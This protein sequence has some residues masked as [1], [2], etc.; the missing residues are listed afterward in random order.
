ML[1]D[2]VVAHLR[3]EPLQDYRH[4]YVGSVASLGL[5][6]GVAQVY[7]VKFRGFVGLVHAPH[8]PR[9]PGADVQPQGP[10]H[11]RL[12]ARPLFR[13]DVVSLG[14]LVQPHRE[15]PTTRPRPMP[16]RGPDRLAAAVTA[17]S[18]GVRRLPLLAVTVLGH[19][20]PGIIADVTG[21][22]AAARRQSRGLHD[23]DAARAFAMMLIVARAPPFRP[24]SSGRSR[25]RRTADHS[26]S[27]Y[28]RSPGVGGVAGSTGR[29]PAHM[30]TGRSPR[31][32]LRR[33]TRVVADVNGNIT[34][35]TTRLAGELYPRWLP[36]SSFRPR[37]T[38]PA[39]SAALTERAHELGVEAT[40]RPAEAD[41]L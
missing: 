25:P 17:A 10:G 4:K 23:D 3:G 38:S 40:L 11:R 1:G 39:L 16:R 27:R 15:F 30:C 35:L 13:R 34:D 19:D 26:R 21:A 18:V 37:S 36:R 41:V 33:M 32:R 24:R 12:D 28:V 9:E 29:V 6:K 31:H 20:R 22:L 14:S 2:N 8:V 7:G 5:H